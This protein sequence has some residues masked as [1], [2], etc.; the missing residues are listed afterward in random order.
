[1]SSSAMEIVRDLCCGTVGG[2]A[3][4]V[5]GQPA[6][7]IKVMLSQHGRSSGVDIYVCASPP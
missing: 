3:G 4:I 1:M 7:T 2:V 6:D 5:V